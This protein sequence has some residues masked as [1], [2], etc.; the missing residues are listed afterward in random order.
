VNP[1]LYSQAANLM[2]QVPSG[3]NNKCTTQG[4]CCREGFFVVGT[5]WNPVVG[6]GV[7]EFQNLYSIAM[8]V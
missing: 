3:G 7:P 8:S 1:L 5:T 6:L 2:K 4:F